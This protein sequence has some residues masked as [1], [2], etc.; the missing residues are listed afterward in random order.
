MD[1]GNRRIPKDLD[2]WVRDIRE[3]QLPVFDETVGRILGLAQDEVTSASALAQVVLQ[4]AHMTSQVLRLV[5]SPLYGHCRSVK[6]ASTV[7]RAIVVLGF[8]AVRNMCLTVTLVDEL[9]KGSARKRLLQGLGQAIHASVHARGFALDRGDPSPE[10]IFIAT[11][12]HRLGELAFWAFGG[13]QCELLEEAL[14]KPGIDPGQA[15]EDVLGFRLQRLS[16]RLAESWKLNDLLRE[17]ISRPRASDVRIQ[18]VT[19]GDSIAHAVTDHGWESPQLKALLAQAAELTG[20]PTTQLKR[21]WVDRA[22]EARQVAN[23]LGAPDAALQIT[24]PDFETHK[25][26]QQSDVGAAGTDSAQEPLAT[27]PFPETNPVLQLNILRELGMFLEEEKPVDFNLIMEMVL[28]G[29]Y[30]GVGLDRTVFALLTPDKKGLRARFA[31]GY[32]QQELLQAF[33]FHRNLEK[34]HLFFQLIDDKMSYFHDPVAKEPAHYA[35]DSVRDQLPKHS[36]MATPIIV[37]G[38]GI[39]LFYGDRGPSKRILTVTDLNSFKYF[40]LQANLCL[41]MT[42][43]RRS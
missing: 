23:E 41:T 33:Q 11:L 4:D 39:G 22:R 10:E 32:H 5:N 9:V 18:L 3:K 7:S 35:P 14:R 1:S 2:G 16:K 21:D 34:P 13:P 8:N 40:V 12:L 17:A 24:V 15:E 43:A 28:E 6:G 25:P 31:L 42:A 26:D 38:L 19:L 36:F 37:N 30:R 29:L 20:R 27:S